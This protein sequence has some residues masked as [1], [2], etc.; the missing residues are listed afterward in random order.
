MISWDKPGIIS[1]N[2]KA[3]PALVLANVLI[4]T[5][6]S[7]FATV[8]TIMAD[9]AIQGSLALSDRTTAWLTTLNLLGINTIVP[10]S[11]WFADRFGYKTM[12]AFGIALFSFASLFAGLSTSF[13]TI[14]LAR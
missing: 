13:A 8:T 12:F 11:S 4:V 1:K 7:V 6:L 9:D 2:N 5:F 10:A 14:C 3:Y